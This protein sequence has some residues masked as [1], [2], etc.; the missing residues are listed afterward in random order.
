MLMYLN[1]HDVKDGKIVAACDKELLGKK[2][3][4]GEKV[5]DLKKHQGFYKGK[6]ATEKQLSDALR[7][8]SS[9]NLIGNKTTSIAIKAGMATEKALAYINS[10][11]YL[12]LYR[13]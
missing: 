8:F 12:Q 9:A 2:L 10:I 1:I 6:V 5:L 7:D 13:L 11:P 4:E 3:S